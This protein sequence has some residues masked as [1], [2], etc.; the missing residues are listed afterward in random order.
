MLRASI[1]T[2]EVLS[3]EGGV[4]GSW[5]DNDVLVKATMMIHDTS[6]QVHVFQVRPGRGSVAKQAS[7]DHAP[8][9][10]KMGEGRA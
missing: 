7:V 6:D 8:A 10:M 1:L 9:E 3:S 5:A 2:G 4:G